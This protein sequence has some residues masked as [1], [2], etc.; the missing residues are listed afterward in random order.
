VPIGPA[1]LTSSLPHYWGAVRFD[2]ERL[3]FSGENIMQEHQQRVVIEKQE[4]DEKREK[5]GAFIE[6]EFYQTL[7]SAERNRLTQQ[8]LAMERYSTILGE[9]IAAF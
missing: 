1:A 3:I 8:A 9:R 4:L 7:S 5:L 2:N 6:S